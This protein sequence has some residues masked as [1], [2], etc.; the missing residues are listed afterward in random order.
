M[1]S[2]KSWTD[3]ERGRRTLLHSH[4]RIIMS[5]GSN[6]RNSI[7]QSVRSQRQEIQEEPRLSNSGKEVNYRQV[8]L[9]AAGGG[10]I[11][12]LTTAAT[13]QSMTESGRC[14]ELRTE[15]GVR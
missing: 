9:R 14:F 10:V 3:M 8:F 11:L 5:D 4:S 2:E 13:V 1:A 15:A 6:H 12:K 7:S